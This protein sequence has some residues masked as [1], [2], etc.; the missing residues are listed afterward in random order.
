MNLQNIVNIKEA[1]IREKEVSERIISE[2][3]Q[4]LVE[5]EKVSAVMI[6]N[7][8]SKKTEGTEDSV[9][10]LVEAEKQ[11]INL[12]MEKSE[13]KLRIQEKDGRIEEILKDKKE[14]VKKIEK[15]HELQVLKVK[16]DNKRMMNQ[17]LLQCD[18]AITELQKERELVEA[19]LR[20]EKKNAIQE[21]KKPMDSGWSQSSKEEI[22]RLK[23]EANKK[24][25]EIVKLNKSN[26]EIKRCWKES[27]RLLKDVWKQIIE[28]T[29]KIQKASKGYK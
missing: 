27:T 25:K 29:A 19:Q 12:K 22:S 4:A 11:V 9:I 24:D 26:Q 14:V 21:W 17:I 23:E 6:E 8:K 20:I 13:L 16:D 2:K 10:K 1:Q 3:L 5:S 15:E 18:E 7:L 28:E